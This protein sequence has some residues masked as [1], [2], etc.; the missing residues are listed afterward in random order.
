MSGRRLLDAL[1]LISSSRSIAT[2]HFAIRAEQLDH[3][4]KT[5]SLSIY[6]KSRWRDVNANDQTAVLSARRSVSQNPIGSDGNSPSS[7]IPNLNSVQHSNDPS[8][9]QKKDEGLGQDHFYN[10]SGNNASTDRLPKD[11]LPVQKEKPPDFTLP[12][13][14]ILSQDANSNR[15]QSYPGH[16]STNTQ[17]GP[18]AEL[19]DVVDGSHTG[20]LS[21]AASKQPL[22][23]NHLEG[24]QRTAFP[25]ARYSQRQAEEQIPSER[26]EPIRGAAS[27]VDT[28]GKL[29]VDQRQDLSDQ[30]P[31]ESSPVKTA[32]PYVKLLKQASN[33]QGSDSGVLNE[34]DPNTLPSSIEFSTGSGQKAM[35]QPQGQRDDISEETMQN[36]FHSKKVANVI[37]NQDKDFRYEKKDRNKFNENNSASSRRGELEGSKT[38]NREL[39]T[40]EESDQNVFVK[41][42]W[43]NS[44][45]AKPAD[46]RTGPANRLASTSQLV[47]AELFVTILVDDG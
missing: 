41:A 34:A 17:R 30:P 23:P 33:A 29:D 31:M 4:S 22:I 11:D 1:T 6:I 2:K 16:F 14:T 18:S 44:A 7:K 9:A 26:V 25:G 27:E 36:L 46:L 20:N 35:V 24:Q 19:T 39:A 13:G 40:R 3:Y 32:F 45:T 5:S 42:P 28:Q 37:F 38:Q 10:W 47:S 15:G 12:G 8:L 21:S 43:V